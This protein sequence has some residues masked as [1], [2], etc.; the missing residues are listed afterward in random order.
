M[1]MTLTV[2]AQDATWNLTGTGDFNTASNW[3]PNTAPTGTAFFGSSNQNNVSF[4]AGTTVGGWIFNVGA[5]NY[6]FTIGSSFLVTFNGAGV[7]I[8]G[9]SANVT[10]N[11]GLGFI[12]GSTAGSAT[13]TNN[14]NIGF[15]DAS[16]AGNA[17]IIN[18]GGFTFDNTSTAGSAT[19]INNASMFL[20][21]TTTAGSAIITNNG[22][23]EFEGTSTAG[24][25]TITNTGGLGFA[26]AATGGTA[27]F[28]NQAGAFIDLSLLTSGGI[29]AG[30][31]EGAGS[32]FL[33][34]KNLA[35]GV[36]NLS[37]TFS[38][39]ISDCGPTGFDCANF[40]LG[41]TTGGSLTK[42]G[43]GM[44]TLTGI[45]TYSGAT[46]VNGGTL[47]V[48]GS[49]A[50]SSMV[51]VNSGGT[52]S[53]IGVVDPATTVIAAGGTLSPGNAA[54]PTGALTITGN[55]AFQS[56]ALYVVQVTPG[57]ASS[58]TVSG[59]ST[60]AGAVQGVLAPGIYNAKT[61]YDILH[62]AGV[63]GTFAGFSSTNMP[64]FGGR[65]T[66][67]SSDVLLNLTAQL[68]A[69]GGLGANQQN[70]ANAINNF[71]NVGGTLPAGFFSLFGQSGATLGNSLAQVSGEA[72]TDA[73]RGAF[74]LMTQF[75]NVMLD[76][77][78]GNAGGASG[79]APER[80][81]SLP[82]DIAAAYASVLKAPVL[83]ASPPPTLRWSVWGAE[84][85]GYNQSSG[86]LATGTTDVV[87]RDYGFVGGMD[88]RFTR[89]TLAGFAL[90][91]GGTNW[92]LAQGLGGGRSD[93]FQAGVYGAQ[94][95]GAAYVTGALGF[96]NH[97]F[98]TNRT[99]LGD[100]LTA[101]FDGQ[102]YAARAEAGYRYPVA[103]VSGALVGVTPY[104]ALQAQW[105]HTP[106]YSETDLTGGGFGL[107]YATMNGS[108][109]RSE[110][111]ARFDDL[112]VIGTIPLILRGRLAWAHDWVSNPTL[113]AVF[114]ALPG[115][116]FTVNGVAPP[117]DSALT[118][119]SAE[120]KLR[121]DVSLSGKFDGEFARNSQTYA[122][123]GTVRW[124]W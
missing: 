64:G 61:T 46:T 57:V 29:T 87:A 80:E 14:L 36:N 16:T 113:G 85:G 28:I 23:L 60:L 97:W 18:N 39:V 58:T 91:G 90:A 26:N 63:G 122:G 40:G 43:T 31:I 13:I 74:Q 30:S 51:T 77:P 20:A 107:N 70:A 115:A 104:A 76:P 27:R 86:N 75:L 101:R 100:Q 50:S 103:P 79:F 73:E 35:V 32:I 42:A 38:G 121:P 44:L 106:A 3:T 71:F 12:N 65:L 112:T 45:N 105:F 110:L 1:A 21:N 123:T 118:T 95:I 109:T 53:G 11:G 92:G 89:D 2:G 98:T 10:N 5:S 62:A 83:K 4:S 22:G 84:F 47:E 124:S 33:G 117:K 114:Q 81:A 19:I 93:A 72:S 25:A 88:Y 68:G 34:S 67:T 119:A 59:N 49:I 94:H 9:G 41:A 24:N 17:T 116:A 69:G 120:L 111:G 37:T 82:P 54:N 96:A 52:L 99:A 7:V 48:D 15:F 102:S 8:N 6:N 56:G 55:L 78:S 108:D 66:Y